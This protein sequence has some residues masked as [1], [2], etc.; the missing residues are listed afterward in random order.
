MIKPQNLQRR[1]LGWKWPAF[2]FCP[3][4]PFTDYFTPRYNLMC[5]NLILK[6]RRAIF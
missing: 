4:V 2:C 1:F 3:I 5:L 6:L